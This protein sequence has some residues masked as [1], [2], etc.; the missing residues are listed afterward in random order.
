MQIRQPAVRSALVLT[1]AALAACSKGDDQPKQAPPPAEVTVVTIAAH[2][3]TIT[4][5]LAGRTVAYQVSDVRPQV[6]GIIQKRL[7]KEGSDVKAGQQLYQIDPRSYQAAYDSARAAEARA[8]ATV[9]GNQSTA[10]RTKELAAIDAA[11]QQNND[12][13]VAALAQSQADVA[14]NKASVESALI[15]LNYTKVTA[16][17]SGRIGKSAF[18]VGALVTSSQADAL[19]TI[20]QLD[21]MY[22]DVT[23]TS[24]DLLRLRRDLESG[25]LKSI[26][27]GQAAVTLKLE[28]GSPYSLPGKLEFADVSVDPT[29]G[30]VIVRAL[31]PNPKGELLPGMYVRT[32]LEEG[33]N[34]QA[35]TV[36]Q[37][38]VTRDPKGGANV[39]V[40]NGENKVESRAIVTDRALGSEWLVSKGLAAGDKVIVEGLQ[41]TGPGATVKPVERS[42]PPA[43]A[44]ASGD[45]LNK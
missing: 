33:V 39:M 35:I 24:S 11:S 31:F 6:G 14:S 7:F 36:P 43:N 30:M 15:N 12:D 1:V 2:P 38:A 4:T 23:Q 16:P 40:V 26:G 22:V 45:S 5:E 21:P 10:Q 19:A 37:Q 29:T 42:A 17:I 20:T 44:A 13:A 41:K 18:T 25:R 27:N 28:D 3:V 8:E 32:Q 34:Q 9:K